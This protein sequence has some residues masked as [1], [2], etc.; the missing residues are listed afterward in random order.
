VTLD[1]GGVTVT[2]GV[3]G[4]WAGGGLLLPFPP[5][6]AEIAATRMLAKRRMTVPKVFFTFNPSIWN[7]WT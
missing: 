1:E 3:V 5:P 2:V 4:F 7:H 6:Q